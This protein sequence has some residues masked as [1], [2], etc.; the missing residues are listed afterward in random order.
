MERKWTV[1]LT[2]VCFL[3][4]LLFG[5]V[6][7]TGQDGPRYTRAELLAMR[8][9]PGLAPVLVLPPEMLRDTS[10]TTCTSKRKRGK[11]GGVRLRMRKGQLKIPL[12]SVILANGQSMRTGS[13]NTK[14]DEIH[15]NIRFQ[16]DYKNAGLLCFTETWWDDDTPPGK[17][18]LDGF[19]APFRMDRDLNIRTDKKGGGG[20]AV[21]VNERWCKRDRIIV[22]KKVCTLDA[23]IISLSFRP[24]H[25]PREFGQVFFTVA[26]VHPKANNRRAAA[27][28]AECVDELKGISPS[29][30]SFV[31]GDLNTCDLRRAL[32]GYTQFVD[33]ETRGKNTLDKCYGN[34]NGA[35]RTVVKPA[36]GRSDH[37]TLL[38][39]PTYQ[40]KL[41][42]EGTRVVERKVWDRETE[43]RMRL[44]FECT[45]WSVLVDPDDS[46]DRNVEVVS[47]YIDFVQ[48]SVVQ[49]K[50]TKVY[51]NN[52]PWI[53]KTLKTKI[54]EKNKLFVEGKEMEGKVIQ[55]EINKEIRK[56]KLELK[57]KIEETFCTGN[58]KSAWDGIKKLT[59]KDKHIQ[60]DDGM[61]D[62]ERK[63]QA[64][65]LNDFYCRFDCS[66]FSAEREEV[67]SC[68]RE[69]L[70]KSDVPVIERESVERTFRNIDTRKAAG[71]DNISGRIIKTCCK[72]LSGV[73]CDIFNKSIET[74]SIPALWKHS[75]I[76]PILKPGKSAPLSLNDYRPIALTS[77]I[78][79]CLERIVLGFLKAQTNLML[80]EH[81]F[82]YRSN[83]SV[84]DAVLTLL[85]YAHTHLD[86]TG[87]D[88]VRIL[89][90]DFSS[91]FNTI[92]PHLLAHKLK[93]MTVNPHLSLWVTDF[94]TKRTQ[95]VRYTL[96][97][98]TNKGKETHMQT[99]TKTIST[100][101]PQG[102]VLSP[103]LFTL[104][105]NDCTTKGTHTSII[106]FSDDTAIVDTS[107]SETVYERE[108]SAFAKW[109]ENHFLDLNVGK[110]K[111]MVVDMKRNKSD[112]SAC[113]IKGQEVERVTVYKYLGTLIDD[114]LTFDENSNVIYKKCR[115][116]MHV[117]Y[118]LRS[119]HVN[120]MILER[121]Y[122]AF[123]QSILAF[124]VICWFG[125]LSAKEKVRLNGVVRMCSK[126]V[127]ARQQSLEEL[128][129]KRSM[130]RAVG[131]LNDH[132][133]V[134]APFFETL[135]S[136]RRLRNYK[137][138]TKRF[139]NTFIP[140]AILLLNSR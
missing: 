48:D 2:V 53:S 44:E 86:K 69:S 33:C 59:G 22:R 85:H 3:I 89:F 133:H 57:S 125:S 124:S 112:V 18:L 42:R 96:D 106:K 76:C 10:E 132:Q 25:L 41:K 123:I 80:D 93:D 55:G 23:E 40:S 16:G 29:A 37:K 1:S 134:L 4:C 116:R 15:A 94:L 131:I 115:Q 139:S 19:G 77:I 79:K 102:T 62:K 137:C 50:K 118:T 65:S 74:H 46:V 140:Q 63:E 120:N 7:A 26:Y 117:L 128:F 45:E 27:T 95:A 68:L 35:Y 30:P 31:I 6:S 127:G 109:C 136:G 97:S 17:L 135:P 36:L 38:F 91:A 114:K 101:A 78:M 107:D 121:C 92:Q 47:D 5:Y 49:T 87:S 126:I 104:Y 60:K 71:P 81:Q 82:A 100:G 54:N 110:T 61:N 113:M 9:A 51:P 84:D 12:P 72:E 20:V 14:L 73:F 34:V 66:D 98:Q 83:R 56:G 52:K 103:F 130:K 28:I 88:Y 90:A 119:L 111:E 129:S 99:N 64:E 43:E 21:Y 75:T 105:T 70:D 32:P 122:Q 58:A 11:R 108:V 24:I 67:I 8:S 39:L 138:R 13:R